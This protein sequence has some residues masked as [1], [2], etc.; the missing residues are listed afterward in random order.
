[1]FPQEQNPQLHWLFCLQC[2]RWGSTTPSSH[3]LCK[4]RC[5][6][7]TQTLELGQNRIPCTRRI[8]KSGCA[9]TANL[10]HQCSMDSHSFSLTG[11]GSNSIKIQKHKIG[12]SWQLRAGKVIMGAP[13]RSIPHCYSPCARQVKGN[14]K[15]CPT[16]QSLLCC[17]KEIAWRL[18]LFIKK[19]LW[20]VLN[21]LLPRQHC[22]RQIQSPGTIRALEQGSLLYQPVFLRKNEGSANFAVCSACTFCTSIFG[23]KSNNIRDSLKLVGFNFLVF[24]CLNLTKYKQR[25]V[26]AVYLTSCYC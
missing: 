3:T 23:L 4:D 18:S 24:I 16:I 26:H 1:M 12:V 2:A 19:S 15:P 10:R 21:Q 7:L 17:G 22:N 8:T 6:Q 5:F 14:L 13:L 25:L 9:W 11:I 20:V